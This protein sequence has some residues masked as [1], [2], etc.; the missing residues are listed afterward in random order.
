MSV[1]ISK[2]AGLAALLSGPA[3]NNVGSFSL[4]GGKNTLGSMR[5]GGPSWRPLELI[6]TSSD[7]S[8]GSYI[9]AIPASGRVQIV[10]DL[11]IT[12]DTN[13]TVTFT[14]EDTGLALG[15]VYVAARTPYVYRPVNGI[16]TWT[17]DKRMLA[18]ASVA[19]N[20]SIRAN[21]HNEYPGPQFTASATTVAPGSGT[22]NWGVQQSG[23]TSR[24]FIT[25]GQNFRIRSAGI[26]MGATFYVPSTY[27]STHTLS[28]VIKVW[29][30]RG[31]TWCL[32]GQSDDLHSRMTAGQ[33]NTLTFN[34]PIQNVEEGDFV[35][36]YITCDT[37]NANNYQLVAVTDSNALTYF[38]T[39]AQATA[40][41]YAW[42]SQTS[43][44]SVAP[45]QLTIQGKVDFVGLGDSIMSG[46]P[47]H[48]SFIEDNTADARTN[49]IEYYLSQLLSE[50]TYI[51]SGIG[52][53][54][55]SQIS[56]RVSTD[57]QS[58]RPRWALLEGGVNDISGGSTTQAQF[59]ANW[60]TI[61]QA[62]RAYNIQPVVLKILPWTNGTNTQM[63]TRDAWNSALV[64]LAQ[65]YGAVIV[66]ASATVGQFR[67]SG[68]AN[69]LWDIATAYSAGDGIHFNAAGYEQI[70][71]AVYAAMI[72][73]GVS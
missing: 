9:T 17:P 31:S 49:T 40:K 69:N 67:S 39:N 18:T 51:N 50:Q 25:T 28:F 10:N 5:D 20:I 32:V 30:K 4:P 11:L 68:N 65:G 6:T 71:R 52:G 16:R 29:R 43:S 59:I 21:Y 54:T 24:D 34:S 62:C 13:M 45:I 12:T 15:A 41:D 22:G 57:L 23:Q 38:V 19:G 26:A 2:I 44:T 58:Y 48:Y 63:Q 70:A 60:T 8:G 61:L 27:N 72:A 33:T 64:T 46:H 42:A 14:E 73:V 55:I 3:Q 1:P 37:N 36:Y 66:D 35:G 7:L 53:Q 47:A 56:G